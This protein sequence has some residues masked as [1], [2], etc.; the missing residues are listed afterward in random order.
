MDFLKSDFKPSGDIITNPP[1]KLADDFVRKALEAVKIGKKVILYLKVNY[2]ASQKRRD[3]FAA[4]PPK[5]VYVL[6]KR[7]SCAKNGE[8]EKY[9]NGAVDYCWFVWEKGYTGETVLKWI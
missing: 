3:L 7:Y 8:F 4:Y 6:S 5:V 2:L 1:Y 9:G